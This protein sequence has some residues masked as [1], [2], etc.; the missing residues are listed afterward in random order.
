MDRKPSKGQSKIEK[1]T[2]L[3]MSLIEKITTIVLEIN[4]HGMILH[5]QWRF[6]K[7]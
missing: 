5:T 4:W 2:V 3:I 6:G 7:W 1:C